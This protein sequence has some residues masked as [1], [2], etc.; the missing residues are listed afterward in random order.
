MYTFF[1]MKLILNTLYFYFLI[2]PPDRI[3]TVTVLL[4][5]I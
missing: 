4:L 5:S 1:F 3:H 2:K